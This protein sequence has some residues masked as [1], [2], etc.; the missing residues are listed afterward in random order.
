LFGYKK[1]EG[2]ERLNSFIFMF[3]WQRIESS[4]IHF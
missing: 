3:N 2:I 4:V 1:S